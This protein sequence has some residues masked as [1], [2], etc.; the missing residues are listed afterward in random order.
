[1]K[2]TLIS[3]LSCPECKEPLSSNIANLVEKEGEIFSGDIACNNC[4][5]KYPIINYIPRFVEPKNYSSSFGYQWNRFSGTQL[6]E[7][8]G[9][10]LSEERFK[11]ETRWPNELH[12]EL[13]L[14]VGSGMGRFTRCAAKTG[15]EIFSFDYSNAIDTNFKNNRHCKNIHFIQA[16]IRKPPFKHKLFDK[17]F[18]FGVLQHTPDPKASFESIFELLKPEGCLVADVYRKTWKTLFWGQ[19]Y[20]RVL[21]KRIPAQKLFPIVKVYFEVVHWFTGLLLPIS[22]HYSKLLSIILGTA[23]YRGMYKIEPKIMKEWCLLDTFDKL[24]PTFDLPQKL[25]G[26]RNWIDT[27]QVQ[28]H[29]VIPGYNGIEIHLRKK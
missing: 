3:Y 11:I 21:T 10:P 8:L 28:S 2:K 29:E 24:S 7:N 14:E 4:L 18:C 5:S 20:L 17:I 26:V 9:V 25:E 13:M 12:G 16:D 1:M 6:D 23:D 15:A 22:S 19:Y 27:N